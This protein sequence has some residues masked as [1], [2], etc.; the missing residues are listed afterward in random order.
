MY[1]LVNSY[2]ISKTSASVLSATYMV[3]LASV[4]EDRVT[5]RFL[6]DHVTDLICSYLCT[7]Y[8]LTNG[9]L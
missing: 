6:D 4:R 9:M 8:I 5:F 1:Y 3:N 7:L 2:M